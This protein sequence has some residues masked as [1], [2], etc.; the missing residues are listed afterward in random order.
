MIDTLDSSRASAGDAFRFRTTADVAA[1]GAHPALPIGTL[2][3]GLVMAAH[4]SARGGRP[5]HIVLE[6]RF[7][8]LAGDTR[9][10][11]ALLPRQKSDAPVFDGMPVNAPGYIGLIPYAGT[12]VGAYNTIHPGHE[13]TVA[14]GTRFPVIVGD[15][16]VLGACR[17]PVES[18]EK[19]Q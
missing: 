11:V 10:P 5:G 9:V 15:G 7:L 2:G 19:K 1:N 3:F 17:L 14:A 13:V 4:H 8:Q 18:T 16:L 12:M 6:A